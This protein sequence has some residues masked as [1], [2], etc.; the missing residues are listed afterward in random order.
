MGTLPNRD[1]NVSQANENIIYL[2]L[3]SLK[4]CFSLLAFRYIINQQMIGKSLF[5]SFIPAIMQYVLVPMEKINRGI[6]F[7]KANPARITPYTSIPTT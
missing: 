2:L 1:L 7:A 5:W 6:Q 4:R 3:P